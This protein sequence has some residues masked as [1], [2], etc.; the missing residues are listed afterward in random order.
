MAGSLAEAPASLRAS[1]P[2]PKIKRLSRL[3][4]AF[5]RSSSEAIESTKRSNRS[6]SCASRGSMQERLTR[7][8]SAS[9]SEGSVLGMS[10]CLAR[11]APATAGRQR[12]QAHLTHSTRVHA[13]L[14]KVHNQTER[15][16]YACLPEA[17]TID[18]A[19]LVLRVRLYPGLRAPSRE[20]PSVTEDRVIILLSFLILIAGGV[21]RFIKALSEALP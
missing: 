7:S 10:S 15:V 18:G 9:I 8:I 17:A 11:A 1:V 20:R 19:K 12:G 16:S 3:M 2:G 5:L 14:P 13:F 6:T 4:E 21:P